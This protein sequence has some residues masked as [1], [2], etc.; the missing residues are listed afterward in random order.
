MAVGA[1]FLVSAAKTWG[2]KRA[3]RQ[4]PRRRHDGGTRPRGLRALAGGAAR[5]ALAARGMRDEGLAPLGNPRGPGQAWAR[6]APQ[7]NLRKTPAA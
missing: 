1:V 3:P 7:S 2:S 4:L 6:L 5:E